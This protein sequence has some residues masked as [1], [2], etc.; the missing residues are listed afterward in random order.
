MLPGISAPSADAYK[1]IGE[2]YP[3]KKAAAPLGRPGGGAKIQ[4]TSTRE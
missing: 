4:L 1:R 2:L 3:V